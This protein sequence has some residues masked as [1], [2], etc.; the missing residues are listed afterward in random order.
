M[1][2]TA[3]G[4]HVCEFAEVVVGTCSDLE[5]DDPLQPGMR[6]LVPCSCGESPQDYLEWQASHVEQ[7]NEAVRQMEPF[8]FLFH[9]A[10]AARRGQ[11]IRY[12]LRPTMRPT[13]NVTEGYKAPY[14]CLADSPSWAWALSGDQRHAPSGDWDLW[15]TS[16]DRLTE[17]IVLAATD[18]P[19]AIHEVRTEH[20]IF[21]RDLW[22][23]G[24]RTRP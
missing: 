3:A 19:S 4:T 16:L 7:M 11:I 14:V 17:P 9:W 18:R 24:S 6:V 1:T 15:Q 8:R 13:T 2:E 20:R 10:P 12:G 22:L 21:K 5:H 23:V